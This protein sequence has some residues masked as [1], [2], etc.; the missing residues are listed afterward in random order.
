MPVTAPLL[1]TAGWTLL[2]FVWQGAAIAVAVA[3][4]L[5]LLERRSANTRYLVACAGL[6]AML[7]APVATARMLWPSV[8]LQPD[9]AHDTTPLIGSPDDVAKA[10]A[11]MAAVGF[12]GT[13]IAF[14]DYVREFPFF[15]AEVLPRL[16][17]MGLRFPRKAD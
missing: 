9:A 17:R 8:V 10:M 12:A 5:R 6:I 15:A 11:E 13:T 2:H 14:V 4:V 1:E 7:A 3:A 16:E